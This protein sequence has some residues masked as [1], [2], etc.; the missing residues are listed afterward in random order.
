VFTV[1]PRFTYL[2]ARRDQVLALI[3][4][5]NAVSVKVPGYQASPAIAYI[6]VWHEG[7]GSASAAIY[8][9]YKEQNTSSAYVYNPRIFPMTELPEVTVEAT[10]F[11]ESMGFM[12]D[13]TSYGTRRPEEQI[14]LIER[15]PLFH[16]DLAKFAMS[17]DDS[18]IPEAV[19]VE[20]I[21]PA[22]SE[23][24]APQQPAER[25]RAIGRLLMS[26]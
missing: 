9:H 24:P 18:E 13:D 21:E 11:L 16:R 17:G 22:D 3:Q 10:E 8:L 15:T 6:V 23:I 26:F 25:T 2:A 4:S 14:A 5:I 7:S 19:I 20:V 1:D 12:L